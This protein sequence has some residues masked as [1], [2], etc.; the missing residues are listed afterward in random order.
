LGI[1]HVSTGEILRAAADGGSEAGLAAAEIMRR[2][3]LVPDD[4]VNALVVQRLAAPD[5]ACGYLMDGYPRTTDQ[6]E[7]FAGARGDEMDFDCVVM[8]EAPEDVLT[9]R[10]LRR[11]A[12]EGR[13][14]DT[15][16]AIR[17]RFEV[18][19][20]QTEP[21]VW[22]YRERAILCEVDGSGAIEEV[23]FRVFKA[24]AG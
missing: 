24:L 10:L 12:E 18:Y 3:D 7:A 11:A 13:G 17:R 19:R 15:A 9:T 14:D 16:D 20:E 2:G 22:Y 21:L 4:I 5:A 8:L 6:A 1:P 23:C